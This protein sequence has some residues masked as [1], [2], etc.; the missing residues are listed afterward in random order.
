MEYL[1]F[2]KEQKELSDIIGAVFLDP[3]S[4]GMWKILQTEGKIVAQMLV[5]SSL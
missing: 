4:S 2:T 3:L 5:H 1:C